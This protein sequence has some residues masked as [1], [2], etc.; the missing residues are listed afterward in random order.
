MAP[1]DLADGQRGGHGDAVQEAPQLAR[2]QIVRGDASLLKAPRQ[3]RWLAACLGL[4]ELPHDVLVLRHGQLLVGEAVE[5]GREVVG[6]PREPAEHL[7]CCAQ[8]Q[9]T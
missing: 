9:P 6:Q 7:A 2:H 5:Q 1:L 4:H 3:A 8:N